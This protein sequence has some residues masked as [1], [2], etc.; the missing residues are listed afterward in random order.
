MGND[1]ILQL[2][3]S[4]VLNLYTM[5]T[6]D[7]YRWKESNLHPHVR[8]MVSYSLNDSDIIGPS[9][10]VRTY[11]LLLPKQAHY[12]AVLYSVLIL[13]IFDICNT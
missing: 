12:Q 10:R 3:Q 1:P 2:S 7:W 8:S 9:S 4:W 11:D 6:I 13:K 5:A